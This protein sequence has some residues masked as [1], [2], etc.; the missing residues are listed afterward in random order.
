MNRLQLL[1]GLALLLASTASAGSITYNVSVNTA[2][3]SG[4]AGFI[5]LQFNQVNSPALSA[6]ATIADFFNTADF[7]FDNSGNFA[8]SGVTGSFSSPPLVIPNDTDAANEFAQ[9]V[10]SFGSAFGFSLT[11]SG[12][13]IGGT[14]DFGSEFFVTLFDSVGGTLIGGSDLGSVA[15]ILVNADGSVTAQ[16][17]DAASVSEA[18]SVPEP[19]TWMTGGLAALLVLARRKRR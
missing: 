14:D 16:S 6:T 10:S 1:S 12:D 9:G 4:T 13:A 17:S 15:S 5:D 19:A 2:S 18:P 8:T 3:I 11:L 7:A